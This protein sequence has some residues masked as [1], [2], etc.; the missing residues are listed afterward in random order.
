MESY[1]S[2]PVGIRAAAAMAAVG[3]LSESIMVDAAST[4]QVESWSDRHG[5]RGIICGRD[6]GKPSQISQRRNS[7]CVCGSG[8]KAKKCC[9]YHPKEKKE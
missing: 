5:S 8:K 3:A 2:L 6:N 1:M 7:Q 4:K 9:I